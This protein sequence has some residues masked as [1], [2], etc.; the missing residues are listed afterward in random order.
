[1]PLYGRKRRRQRCRAKTSYV[2]AQLQ[3]QGEGCS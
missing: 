2:G 1:L 3:R